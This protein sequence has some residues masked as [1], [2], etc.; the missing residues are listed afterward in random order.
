[1]D[2][3]STVETLITTLIREG[4]S[5]L[6]LSALR[7]PAIRVHGELVF[8]VNQSELSQENMID[9]LTF[10][11]GKERFEKFVAEKEFDFSYT[12]GDSRLRGNAFFQRGL[13]CMT[14]RLIP[15]AATIADL[16]LP[17]ILESFARRKQGF[18]LVVGPV[19][20]GKSTTLSAMINLINKERATHIVTIEDPIE[21]V[22]EPD[23]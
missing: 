19:G 6:H 23:K 8:L 7:K 4:G 15:K 20:Q 17:A 22:Y 16:R 12:F 18:F 14:F 5:D 11:L 10:L 13:I 3:K 2:I 21:F 1:M 9:I